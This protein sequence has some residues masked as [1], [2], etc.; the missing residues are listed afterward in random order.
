MSTIMTR[1][2]QM[3]LSVFIERQLYIRARGSVRYVPLSSR[4]QIALSVFF[5]AFAGWFSYATVNVIFKDEIAAR[6]VVNFW[7]CSW[8]MKT[9]AALATG[10]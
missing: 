5:L 1:I 8:L 10:L 3:L 4:S 7:K 6:K 9:V 2:K